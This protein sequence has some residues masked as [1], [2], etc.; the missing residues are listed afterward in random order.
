MVQRELGMR[1]EAAEQETVGQLRL[2]LKEAR[3]EQ[4]GERLYPK[5]LNRM[6]LL[7][8][9]VEA[10][11]RGLST[12]R[13][14]GTDKC[15]EELIRDIKGKPVVAQEKAPA[16][17][18]QPRRPCGRARASSGLRLVPGPCRGLAVPPRS[19]GQ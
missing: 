2:M 18:G 7:E 16:S 11:A 13:A 10:A 15:S 9:Q 4:A 6:C 3:D 8:L 5:G 12:T 17:A 1:R 19:A 14:N